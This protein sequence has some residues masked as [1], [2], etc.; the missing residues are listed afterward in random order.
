MDSFIYDFH[1]EKHLFS[2]PPKRAALSNCEEFEFFLENV[3]IKKDYLIYSTQKLFSEKKYSFLF[4]ITVFLNC[5]DINYL[6]KQIELFNPEKIDKLEVFSKDKNLLFSKI[7]E[8]YGNNPETILN[9]TIDNK[10]KKVIINLY[11]LILFFNMNYSISKISEFLDIKN[12]NINDYISYALI[13][14]SNFFLHSK[15][16]LEYEIIMN[17]K[18]KIDINELAKFIKHCGSVLD[19]LKICCD[20]LIFQQLQSKDIQIN[21]SRIATPRENDNLKEISELYLDYDRKRKKNLDRNKNNVLD[22]D[23]FLCSKYINL[24]ENKNIDNLFYVKNIIDIEF[25]YFKEKIDNKIYET[26]IYLAKKKSLNNNQIIKILN[27][28]M[29]NYINEYYKY[30]YNDDYNLK[31][32]LEII[33]Q[34]DIKS[35]DE[36]FYSEFEKIIIL[37]KKEEYKEVYP[38]FTQDLID[39]IKDLEDFNI[40][41]KKFTNY[42]QPKILFPL[43]RKLKELL[44]ENPEKCATFSY[45]IILMLYISILDKGN[46]VQLIDDFIKMPIEDDVREFLSNFKTHNFNYDHSNNIDSNNSINLLLFVDFINLI[47][48]REQ[49]KKQNF[50]LPL[51]NQ[52]NEEINILQNNLNKIKAEFEKEKIKNKKLEE[53]YIQLKNNNIEKFNEIIKEKEEEI[54]KLKSTIKEKENILPISITDS[55]E[56]I[57]FC[58]ICRNIDKFYQIEKEFYEENPELEHKGY[59]KINNRVLDKQKSI[60][61]NEIHKNNLIIYYQN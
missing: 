35:C 22:F 40:F 54:L 34:L 13:Y 41:Q 61:E 52:S 6:I 47:K 60:E 12:N 9:Y 48:E 27:L 45:E 1:F 21:I 51:K 7:L 29:N 15:I 17:L 20:D 18:K 30:K 11:A 46:Y 42:F 50:N 4:Y 57:Y 58:T 44:T 16:E 53:S 59:F 43:Q 49:R 24:F 36:Q 26:G 2:H 32:R 55:E 37:L 8:K 38:I 28:I 5:N 14:Y 10:D 3:N 23:Y 19:I 31:E 39:S 25:P 33:K 56:S